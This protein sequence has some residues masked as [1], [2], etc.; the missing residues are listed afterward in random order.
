VRG[1]Q[2]VG[3]FGVVTSTL[4][5]N[6]NHCPAVAI[7]SCDYSRIQ[8][9][10]AEF[11]GAVV[12]GQLSGTDVTVADITGRELHDNGV[13]CSSGVAWSISGVV[14]ENCQGNA[15]QTRGPLMTVA[16]VIGRGCRNP[17]LDMTGLGASV[18]AT[19]ADAAGYG[20]T[21]RNIVAQESQGVFRLGAQG[22]L[23]RRDVCVSGLYA[24]D[25][26]ITGTAGPV[27][28]SA[29]SGLVVSDVVVRRTTSD[30]GVF[31]G[32]DSVD[33]CTGVLVSNLFVT[34]VNGSAA[35][36]RGGLRLDYCDDAHVSNCV[37]SDIASGIGVRATQCDGLTIAGARYP[38]GQAV[39]VPSGEGNANLTL[40]GIDSNGCNVDGAIVLARASRGF[41]TEQSGTATI[42]GAATSVTVAHGLSSFLASISAANISVTPTNNLGAASRLWVSNV[43][44]TTF[45]VNCD[46]NPGAGGATFAWSARAP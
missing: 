38:G 24:Y 37:F 3:F 13:Y 8:D 6:A 29:H 41:V 42:P 11:H 18:D 17:V 23:Y 5:A 34:D 32:G 25:S 4:V 33:K 15:V 39:R 31:I 40:L 9:G 19:G 35:A 44:A 10:H 14:V 1:F 28:I 43:T 20:L 2:H 30:L 16:N 27:L 22:G 45:D 36:T 7:R 21:A 46:T 26:T 12:L